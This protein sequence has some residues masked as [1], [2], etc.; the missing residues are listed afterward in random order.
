MALIEDQRY[1]PRILVIDD[2]QRIRDGCSKILKKERCLV[3]T[4][5]NGNAG[6]KMIA[7]RHYDIVLTDLMMPGI[8]GME[9]GNKVREKYADTVVIVITG[10]AQVEGDTVQM[11]K[12]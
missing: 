8:G 1:Q 6:I 11:K 2:E 12:G 5:E 9:E 7:D 10:F 3:D 4:A